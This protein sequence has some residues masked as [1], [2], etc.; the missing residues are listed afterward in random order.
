MPP[1]PTAPSFHRR[2]PWIAFV[3]R[4]RV[5][6][7]AALVG[8]ASACSLPSATDDA[9]AYAV[10]SRG[11]LQ[12]IGAPCPMDGRYHLEAD[13]DLSASDWAPI[14]WSDTAFE[15]VLDGRGHAI[16]NLTIV[17]QVDLG[18][19]Q[20]HV[21]SAVGLFYALDGATVR[22][23]EVRDVRISDTESTAGV[24]GALAGRVVGTQTTTLSGVDVRNVTAEGHVGVGGLVGRVDGPLDV[25]GGS[26]HDARL[27]VG[28]DYVGGLVGYSVADLSVT[29]VRVSGVDARAVKD[30]A[31]GLVGNAFDGTVTIL[32]TSVSGVVEAGED[33]V[34]GFLGMFGDA[35]GAG[36]DDLRILGATVAATISAT[37]NEAGGLVGEAT[38][39]IVDVGNVTLKGIIFAG[40]KEA[41]GAFG[42]LEASERADLRTV[43]LTAD[44]SGGG[45]VGGLAGYVRGTDTLFVRQTRL[46]GA[47]TGTKNDVGGI[48]GLLRDGTSVEVTGTVF[49]GLQVTGGRQRRG[50][51]RGRR[52][53]DR[54][55][56]RR[57]NGRAAHRPRDDRE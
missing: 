21:V 31:G 44:V 28:D 4:V 50:H 20:S 43:T 51:P 47:V 29:E 1:S 55:P 38:G 12:A 24:M 49:A 30:Y 53:G 3:A 8:V 40:N 15:G 35:D 36:T 16:T 39:K 14:G 9:G 37:N 42:D 2:R 17:S 23:L 56:R 6:A 18:G 32:G 5:V 22:S 19:A 52:G 7:V 46:E 27:R 54:E 33:T 25:R 26:V 13:V 41:G 11:D 48:V 57:S 10:V 45:D 34:G